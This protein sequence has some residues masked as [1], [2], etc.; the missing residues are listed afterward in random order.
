MDVVLRYV[1]ELWAPKADELTFSVVHVGLT[2]HIEVID[3]SW[4]DTS[5]CVP[6]AIV[7][8]HIV[9]QQHLLEVSCAA[10]PVLSQV[11][12][13]VGGDNLASA[14]AHEASCVELSHEGIYYRHASAALLPSSDQF[15]VC[16]PFEAI[17]AFWLDALQPEHARLVALAIEAE[18][19]SPAQ[20][21]VKVSGR[22]V[23]SDLLLELKDVVV[24]LTH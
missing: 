19:F 21:K 23:L 11:K 16:L 5:S 24:E 22:L 17:S 20:L 18:E 14:I 13:Q 15:W 2:Q 9:I 12:C 6:V 7:R 1:C 8:M 4:S 10:S 3:A